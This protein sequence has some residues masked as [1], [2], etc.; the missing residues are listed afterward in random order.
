MHTELPL[1]SPFALLSLFRATSLICFQQEK[2]TD[3]TCF[4]L[5]PS[6]LMVDYLQTQQM[7]TPQKLNMFEEQIIMFNYL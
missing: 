6:P 7:N 4:T 2:K 3:P 1:I 5:L